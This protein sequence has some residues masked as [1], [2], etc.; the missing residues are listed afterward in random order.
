M[1]SPKCLWYLWVPSSRLSS[2]QICSRDREALG[3]WVWN[4]VLFDWQDCVTSCWFCDETLNQGPCFPA[5]FYPAFP[6]NFSLHCWACDS[7]W[8]FPLQRQQEGLPAALLHPLSSICWNLWAADSSLRF[9][10]TT[11]HITEP[12][13]TAGP[14][15]SIQMLLVSHHISHANHKGKTVLS[16]TFV[17][18]HHQF[19]EAKVSRQFSVTSKY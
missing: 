19:P 1:S 15:P 7:L 13:D 4:A 10:L 3:G 11:V 14:F 8:G 6:D 18:R 17:I 9:L 5:P 12:Q 2:N 16:Y